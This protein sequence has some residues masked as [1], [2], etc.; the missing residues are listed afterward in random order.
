MTTKVSSWP[1]VV[2][3]PVLADTP[4]VSVF[5]LQAPKPTFSSSAGLT[6]HEGRSPDQY[7][8]FGLRAI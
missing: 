3:R 5:S 1:N 8:V 6:S 4:R 7:L 2:L